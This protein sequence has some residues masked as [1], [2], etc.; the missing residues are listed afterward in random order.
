MSSF[1]WIE[2]KSAIKRP[3]GRS[4]ELII[5]GPDINIVRHA[6]MFLALGE[7]VAPYEVTPELVT[8][9]RYDFG[10]ALPLGMCAHPKIDPATGEMIVFRYGL[11]AP[12]LYWAVIGADG[13]VTHPPDVIAEVD[14]GYM[15]HDFSITQDF[16]VLVVNPVTFDLGRAARR[17]SPLGWAAGSRCSV[18]GPPNGITMTARRDWLAGSLRT[19]PLLDRSSCRR[20]DLID[21]VMMTN[22]VDTIW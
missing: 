1:D 19:S 14:R 4:N 10:G 15:I 20:D 18:A 7:G 21:S 22:T 17:E 16:V 3:I 8:V 12:Y 5:G 2:A 6:N 9:G 11:E 13:T